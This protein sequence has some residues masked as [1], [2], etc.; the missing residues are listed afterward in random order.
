[1]A[2]TLGATTCCHMGPVA[3][4]PRGGGASRR[5][6]CCVTPTEEACFEQV[7]GIASCRV[8]SPLLLVVTGAA[9]AMTFERGHIVTVEQISAYAVRLACID[10]R[11]VL[12]AQNVD[13]HGDRFHMGR[14]HACP[15]AALVIDREARR[16]RPNKKFVG[17]P[18]RLDPLTPTLNSPYPL[19][20]FPAVQSQQS[21][22]AC[23]VAADLSGEGVS[24]RGR[25][26]VTSRGT[27]HRAP[28]AWYWLSI[29]AST[30][31]RL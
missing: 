4:S 16:D 12:A 7:N 17:E 15:D 20:A 2:W 29:H 6:S 1:M 22:L 19:W 27:P 23:V 14:I 28:S 18:V 10:C 9:C 25:P 8:P 3:S 26:L 31:E 21:V 11:R 24:W 30:S 5:R 13:S